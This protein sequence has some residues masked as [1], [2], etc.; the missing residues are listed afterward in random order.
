MEQATLHLIIDIIAK[1]TY[2]MH[3][4]GSVYPA[5]PVSA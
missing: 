3:F 4:R 5:Q 1:L 2:S